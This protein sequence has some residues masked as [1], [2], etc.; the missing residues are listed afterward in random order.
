MTDDLQ[1]HERRALERER[2][3]RE[4][5]LPI[6]KLLDEVQKLYGEDE[7]KSI[8][9]VHHDSGSVELYP[10]GAL[11]FYE[12]RAQ[13]AFLIVIAFAEMERRTR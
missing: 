4:C 11:K 8:G 7:P 9:M 3:F 1:G 2:I 13:M 5:K 6:D 12:R 10:D